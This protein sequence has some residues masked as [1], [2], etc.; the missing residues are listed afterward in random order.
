MMKNNKYLWKKKK[1]MDL[2]QQEIKKIKI[3]TVLIQTR[4]KN[5]KNKI[6][7]KKKNNLSAQKKQK[8]NKS[9]MP[10]TLKN[11]KKN[12]NNKKTQPNKP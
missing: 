1:M 9:K 6:I 4:I 11:N 8:N 5:K 2:S 12:N 3:P 7:K 10:K